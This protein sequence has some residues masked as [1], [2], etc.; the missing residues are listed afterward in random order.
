MLVSFFKVPRITPRSLDLQSQAIGSKKHQEGKEPELRRE[1]A[2]AELRLINREME[3]RGYR[4]IF[5][6]LP[7][8][9]GSLLGAGMTKWRVKIVPT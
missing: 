2:M 1:N 3:S 4:E 7:L 5:G 6:W 9:F 8:N